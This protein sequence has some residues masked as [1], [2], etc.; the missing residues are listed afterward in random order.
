MDQSSILCVPA[1]SIISKIKRWINSFKCE[2]KYT[3]KELVKFGEY[4]LSDERRA[5]YR[6]IK[7]HPLPFKE[8]IKQI[9]H[10][11]IENFKAIL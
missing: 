7:D 6:G 11:D 4:I 2:R 3:E 10:S 5:L 9:N 8:R 1:M